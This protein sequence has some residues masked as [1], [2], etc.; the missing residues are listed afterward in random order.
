MPPSRTVKRLAVCLVSIV[1]SACN[2]GGGSN[3]LFSSS[4][5]SS[6]GS[7]SG[8]NADPEGIWTGED[9]ASG[10]PMVGIVEA[11]GDF[12]FILNDGVQFIGQAV[13]A[14]TSISAVDE[15]ITQFGGTAF[16]NDVTYG[17]GSF[18]GT[19][20]AGSSITASTS[21]TPL[22]DMTSYTGTW[23]LTFEPIYNSGS[24]LSTI[25]GN[26]TNPSTSSGPS[27]GAVVS[28]SSSGALTAQDP[29]SSC[30]LS[31]QITP[32][33]PTYDAYSVTYT[34]LN[35]GTGYTQLNNVPLAGLGVFVPATNSTPAQLIIGVTGISSGTTYGDVLQL[36]LN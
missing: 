18:S 31:G 3:S 10:Q 35:C 30:I 14:G 15:G 23:S 16:P 13:V 6:G 5:S 2:L 27:S 36:T 32:I 33:N 28:I 25:T 7:S 1:L 24:S 29:T 4:S 20:A 12:D 34:Y 11:S 17:T 21:F 8:G 26:Y 19:L 22:N 9:T